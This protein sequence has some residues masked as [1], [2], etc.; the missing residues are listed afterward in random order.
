MG[1]RAAL[2]RP[3]AHLTAR[4]ID[5]MAANAL[6][7]QEKIF[8]HLLLRARNT[9]FG[10]DHHFSEINTFEDFTKAVPIRDYEALKQYVEK[11]KQGE[12]NVLWPGKPAYF[13]KTSGTTS[14]VKYIPMS[15]EST[16]L[17]FGTARNALFNYFART[18]RGES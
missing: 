9:T 3:F 4:R 13:A 12:Q 8:R 11:I 10:R 7:D 1:F 17:H 15:R 16:P 2:I 14:G 6:A 5:R 18:G